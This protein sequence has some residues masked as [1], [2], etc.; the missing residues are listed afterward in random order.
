MQRN[1]K[2]NAGMGLINGIGHAESEISVGATAAGGMNSSG[3]GENL[4]LEEFQA[5]GSR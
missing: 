1:V 5:G 3:V 2:S 4:A